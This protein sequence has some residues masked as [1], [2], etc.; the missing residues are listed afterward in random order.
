MGRDLVA[1]SSKERPGYGAE[2]PHYFICK[3][4]L[5]CQRNLKP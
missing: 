3:G 4:Q 5:K 1:M 2:V